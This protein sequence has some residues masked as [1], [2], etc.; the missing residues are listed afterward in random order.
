MCLVVAVAGCDSGVY[1]HVFLIPVRCGLLIALLSPSIHLCSY[2]IAD[3]AA[4]SPAGCGLFSIG[5][6]LSSTAH[7]RHFRIRPTE[8]GDFL[9]LLP[10]HLT[11]MFR[12]RHFPGKHFWGLLWRERRWVPKHGNP[13]FR[14]AFGIRKIF[15]TVQE[16]QLSKQ[17]RLDTSQALPE[18][19]AALAARPAKSK[20]GISMRRFWAA[21]GICRSIISLVLQ[22]RVRL[23]RITSGRLV[24]GRGFIF[25]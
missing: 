11:L 9:S 5:A 3:L 10:A 7:G 23:A 1:S 12:Y 17:I 4:T 16:Q 24:S 20:P 19:Y 21:G 18:S 2:Q 13:I 8:L 22:L 25:C 6:F 14:Y 15:L